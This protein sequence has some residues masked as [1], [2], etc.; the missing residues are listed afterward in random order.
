MKITKEQIQHVDNY[1]KN[2]GIKF[3]DVRLEMVDHLV[4]DME[5]Y[6]GSADFQTVF[7]QS[8]INANWYKNLKEINVQSWKSTNKLYRKKHFTEMVNLVK[9]PKSLIGFV[10][11]YLIFSR[12]TVVF[13]EVSE[14]ISLIVLAAPILILIYESAKAWR[15]K[16]GRSVNMQ[17]GLFYFSFGLIMINLPLELLP[18]EYLNLLLPLIMTFYLLMM[19]AGYKVYIYAFNKALKLKHL[20]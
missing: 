7:R 12:V 13:S 18:K 17:Y 2:E 5:N 9:Q 20:L 15:K 19:T 3:W 4:S 1:L 10:L 16:L 11:F 6:S 8:L 14:T